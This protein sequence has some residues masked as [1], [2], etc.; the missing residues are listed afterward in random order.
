MMIKHIVLWQ[1]TEKV[2]KN[3]SNETTKVLREKFKAL[4]GVI[5]GLLTIEL[6]DN[7]KG[8]DYDIALYCEFETKED[9]ANYQVAP[10]HVAIKNLSKDW[11]SGRAAI[12]YEI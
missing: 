8:G 10:E 12:D 4:L 1:Y 7:Y 2:K 9:E 3:N 5:P 11:V 6:G